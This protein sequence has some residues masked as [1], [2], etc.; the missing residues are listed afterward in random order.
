M[1][2]LGPMTWDLVERVNH[3]TLNPWQREFVDAWGRGWGTVVVPGRGGGKSFVL[4]AI[5]NTEHFMLT[6]E[7]P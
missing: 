6:G 7:L 3:C 1:I 5:L 4:R 2:P